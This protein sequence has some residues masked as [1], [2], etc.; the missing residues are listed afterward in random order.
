VSAAAVLLAGAAMAMPG[1]GLAPA[2][3]TVDIDGRRFL[4][5]S[6]TA[7]VGQTVTWRNLDHATHTVS[8]GPL[9]SGRLVSGSSY[10]HTFEEPGTY[11]YLCTLHRTMRGTVTVASLGLT[12]PAAPVSA[13]EHALLEALVPPGTQSVTLER[14]GGGTVATAVPDESGRAAFHVPASEP[15][16]YRLRAGELTSSAV[17]VRVAPVVRMT[18]GR[19]GERIRVRATITPAQPGATIALERYVRERF[20][21][22]RVTAK[23]SATGTSATFT[24]RDRRRTALKVAVVKPL[25]GWSVGRSPHVTLRTAR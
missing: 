15:G 11:A 21:Y 13:G 18:A 8:G 22:R 17:R 5:A 2:T 3:A 7:L 4:P 24:L 16:S 20:D 9:S 25:R 10:A 23:R 19:A 1:H 6:L 12:G 14:V